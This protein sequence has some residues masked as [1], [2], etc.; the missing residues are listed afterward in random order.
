ML[1]GR[2]TARID[3]CYAKC[4]FEC[5]LDMKRLVPYV[6]K[7]FLPCAWKCV[8]HC[9]FHPAS[10]NLFYYQIG[11][12]IDSCFDDIDGIMTSLLP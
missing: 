6:P 11:C 12:A 1:S 5:I 4:Y 8:K 7:K 2:A 3:E 10:A 9:I